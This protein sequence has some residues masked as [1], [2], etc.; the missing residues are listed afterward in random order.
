MP[1]CAVSDFRADVRGR[2]RGET[3]DFFPVL[4]SP[5][6]TSVVRSGWEVA[7]RAVARRVDCSLPLGWEEG[8]GQFAMVPE[9]WGTVATALSVPAEALATVVGLPGLGAEGGKG[10]SRRIFGFLRR[11][12]KERRWREFLAL[13]DDVCTTVARWYRRVGTLSWSQADILQVMEE[14]GNFAGRV[15]EAYVLDTLVL[16]DAVA[17]HLEAIAFSTLAP[18]P[19]PSLEPLYRFVETMAGKDGHVGIAAV[20]RSFPWWGAEP[21]EAAAARWH[22]AP[23]PLENH[24]RERRGTDR[25]TRLIPS[26]PA[27]EM[28][29]WRAP[30]MARE[31]ARVALA[32]VM[33]TARRWALAAAG[34]A[35]EDGRIEARDEVF[36]LELEELKQM[37]TGEW[38]DPARVRA[39][40]RERRQEWAER[41]RG[42]TVHPGPEGRGLLVVSA[43]Q[44][45]VPPAGAVVAAP[46]WHPGYSV[47]AWG[48]GSLWTLARGTFSYGHLLARG[49]GIGV[50]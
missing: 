20:A 8:D 18:L 43:A 42:L 48:A 14:I 44:P 19:L 50:V 26:R 39:I 6:T 47:S 33:T 28:F 21:F 13:S 34:E 10:K 12:R 15:L 24:V 29:P 7:R 4:P 5:F 36:F 37:M 27:D 22:E 31:S 41:A 23:A 30:L 9:F 40:V 16:A 11:S 49:L 46:G 17:P 3:V 1:W 38:S 25:P 35:L 45:V 2:P 32:L